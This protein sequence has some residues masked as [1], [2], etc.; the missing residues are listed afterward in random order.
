MQCKI[1]PKYLGVKR[2][3]SKVNDCTCQLIYEHKNKKTPNFI[4]G[5]MMSINDWGRAGSK[6]AKD[7]MKIL[8]L[9]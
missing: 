6:A 9:S 4:G 1:H 2:P 3:K 5:Q 8:P 7:L